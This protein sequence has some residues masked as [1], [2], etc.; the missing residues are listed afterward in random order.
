MNSPRQYRNVWTLGSSYSKKSYIFK[1]KAKYSKSPTTYSNST[2]NV[3]SPASH[4]TI[5]AN[6]K[7]AIPFKKCQHIRLSLNRTYSSKGKLVE[8]IIQKYQSSKNINK[9]NMAPLTS[10]TSTDE[11]REATITSEKL[12]ITN[13]EI[14]AEINYPSINSKLKFALKKNIRIIQSPDEESYAVH[15]A[16]SSGKNNMKLLADTIGQIQQ[17]EKEAFTLAKDS[18]LLSVA[19]SNRL[20]QKINLLTLLK[21]TQVN[22]LQTYSN[23]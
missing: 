3:F 11:N 23:T 10:E 13:K 4:R 19:T 7:T 21:K 1:E 20:T 5:F 12:E 9:Q 15:K 18:M 8:G 6:Q 22:Y 16:F 2:S 14:A 17:K